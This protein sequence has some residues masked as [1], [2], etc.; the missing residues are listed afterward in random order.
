MNISNHHNGDEKNKPLVVLLEGN[1]GAGK[2]TLAEILGKSFDFVDVVPEPVSSWGFDEKNNLLAY[3]YSDPKRW[4]FTFQS[5]VFITRA[6]AHI[7][8][9]NNPNSKKIIVMDRSVYCDKLC[10]A[11]NCFNLGM[12]SKTEWNTYKK[13]FSWITSEFIHPPDGI[14]YLKVSPKMCLERINNRGR[15]EERS[16]SLD[17]L[18]S[19]ET[20]HN[21]W[22]F[23]PNKNV[24]GFD[25]K[26]LTLNGDEDFLKGEAKRQFAIDLI[27]DFF[28]SLLSRE[29]SIG[30][31]VSR[32][33][34]KKSGDLGTV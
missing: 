20:L 25:T 7:E 31:R 26:L 21:E 32:Y 4:A 8:A 15:V 14:I 13:V 12:M 1:M 29:S 2:T 24:R 33:S 6:K 27:K 9:V 19:L 22:L 5:H 34:A 28:G 3:F 11:Q 17:Y 16:V 18:K 30:K 23:G 10:F